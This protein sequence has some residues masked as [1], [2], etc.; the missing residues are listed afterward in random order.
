[1]GTP[2]HGM[3]PMG[4]ASYMGLTSLRLTVLLRTFVCS[5]MRTQRD[6][7][8]IGTGTALMTSCQKEFGVSM[9]RSCCHG[10]L[11]GLMSTHIKEKNGTVAGLPLRR[12]DMLGNGSLMPVQLHITTFVKGVSK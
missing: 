12:M 5:T 4:S 6:F 10:H 9:M 3:T 1:M 11:G 2:N 7:Q 8:L